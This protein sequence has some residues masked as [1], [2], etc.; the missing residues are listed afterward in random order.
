MC[1]ENCEGCT[2]C[3]RDCGVQRSKNTNENGT[4]GVCSVGKNPVVARAA[5]HFWE[6]PCISGTGGSGTVFFSGCP[7]KCVFCQNSEIS[8]GSLG[9]EITV[10]RLREIYSELIWQGADNINLVTPTHY[11]DAICESLEGI[12]LPVPVVYNTGGYDKVAQLKRLEGKIQIYMP[13]F[14]YSSSLSAKKYS[15]AADYPSVAAAAVR[16]MY[17][18]CGKPVYDEDGMLLS[19]VIVRHLVLPGE[20]ENTLDVIDRVTTMFPH[21]EVLFSL[22]SQYTPPEKKLKYENLNRRLSQEEYSQAVDYLYLSGMEDGF[23][24]ELSSAE[25]EYTP[26]FDL[27]GV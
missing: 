11:T 14:K 27:S 16:E 20:L 12:K 26:P 7:L 4:Y 9:R 24:Q 10:Q 22:M 23:V 17:R 25:S 19:G 18:Q 6:E 13:D 2:L 8:R 5:L 3:P 21:G 15:G 1:G